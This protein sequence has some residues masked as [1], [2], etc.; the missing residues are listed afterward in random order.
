MVLLCLKVMLGIAAR[1]FRE[2]EKE[3]KE[4]EDIVMRAGNPFEYGMRTQEQVLTD[5]AT[6]VLERVNVTPKPKRSKKS[7]S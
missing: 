7:N 2:E 4:F 1:Y 3:R 6:V 5:V